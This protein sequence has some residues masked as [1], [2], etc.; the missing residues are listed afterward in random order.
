MGGFAQPVL[1]RRQRLL[2]PTTLDDVIPEGHDVRVLDEI[3]RTLD[4]SDWQGTYHLKRGQPPILPR[5]IA[6]VILYGLM[7]RVRSSRVLEYMTGN[8][9]DFI[10]LTESRTIDH[11]TIA[12][13]RTRFKKELRELFRQTGRIAMKIGIIRLGE[14]TFDGTRVKAN[15][16][17][18]ETCTA[19][20]LEKKLAELV[21]KFGQMLDEAENIDAVEDAQ[22]GLSEN[23][24]PPDLVDAKA[25][26]QKLREAI[27][28]LRAA[29]AMRRR[30]NK[31]DPKENPSQ[32]PSTDPD[33]KVLPNKEGGY[34]P[35][36]TPVTGVDTHSDFIVY[37]DVI[38]DANENTHTVIMVDQITEDFGQRPQTVL[39]DG[40]NATG[41]NIAAMQE[42]N[43]EFLSPLPCEQSV[44][45]P[46][47]RANPREA[48]AE[49]L[50]PQLPINPQT[51]A[52]DK[53]CFIYDAGSD[54]YYCPMGKALEF[55][56]ST[57]DYRQGEKITLRIYRCSSCK[58]CPLASQCLTKDNKHGRTIRRDN[59][60]E[61]REQHATKMQTTEAREKYER[62]FHAAETPFA[63]LKHVLG[64]RQFLLRGLENVQTEWIWACTAYN[65]RKLLPQVA[66]LRALSMKRTIAAE[67]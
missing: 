49:S 26:S 55:E 28:E 22:F 63:W 56:K 41:P 35:N 4:W 12:G 38:P 17:R 42:R 2:I 20:D 36:Y 24:L 53:T 9:V 5:V 61:L 18:F 44:A 66:K 39:T 27:Q 3:L 31:T 19:D 34:A 25:R 13:F 1:A 40:L 65:L 67:N 14:I 51:K 7:R 60:T 15:N 46:V 50:L 48:I 52:F 8:N 37:A 47:Q 64:L 16:G 59:Y 29:E 11:S 43:V 30:K 32:M 54:R 62:R 21:E 23:A 33:S 10:W 6:S 45:D 58:D 57:S